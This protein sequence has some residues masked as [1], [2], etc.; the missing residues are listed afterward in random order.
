MRVLILFLSLLFSEAAHAAS[1]PIPCSGVDHGTIGTPG[2]SGGTVEWPSGTP[3]DKID[4]SLAGYLCEPC[5]AAQQTESLR[6]DALR[7]RAQGAIDEGRY[8]EA[9]ATL[10]EAR[11]HRAHVWGEGGTT[12][13]RLLEIA[14]HARRERAREERLAAPLRRAGYLAAVLALLCAAAWLWRAR[15]AR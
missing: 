11:R 5:A 8:D 9:L 1:Y 4:R 3:Q 7:E 13:A 14:G 12:D 6:V 15:R 2:W 10:D